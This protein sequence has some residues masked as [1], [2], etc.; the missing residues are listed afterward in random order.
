MARVIMTKMMTWKTRTTTKHPSLRQ[1][2]RRTF[3]LLVFLPVTVIAETNWSDELTAIQQLQAEGNVVQA[4]ID[5]EALHSQN[6][7]ASR[8]KLELAALY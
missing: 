2:L 5:L 1:R 4:V 6:P 8:L 7:T 3:W